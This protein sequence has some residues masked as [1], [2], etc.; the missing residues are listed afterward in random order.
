MGKRKSS[1]D[2]YYESIR[3]EMDFYDSYWGRYITI[4]NWWKKVFLITRNMA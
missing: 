2:S 3:D 1:K 4:S